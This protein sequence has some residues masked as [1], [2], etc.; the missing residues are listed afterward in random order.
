MSHEEITCGDFV[1]LGLAD[2]V[3]GV[4]QKR[5]FLIVCWQA[6]NHKEFEAFFVFDNATDRSCVLSWVEFTY[7][8]FSSD[9]IF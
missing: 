6:S 4:G 9:F 2:E 3:V 8:H 5:I 1:C 7:G